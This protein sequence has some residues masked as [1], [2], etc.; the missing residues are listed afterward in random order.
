MSENGERDAAERAYDE[1]AQA[2]EGDADKAP[3]PAVERPKKERGDDGREK[4]HHP[5]AID[6]AEQGGVD[7][8]RNEPENRRSAGHFTGPERQDAAQ[9]DLQVAGFEEE[10]RNIR[11]RPIRHAFAVKLVRD[12]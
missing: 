11:P 9:M 1:Q 4:R 7:E 3:G 6:R 5:A 10:H 2:K 12:P 8:H